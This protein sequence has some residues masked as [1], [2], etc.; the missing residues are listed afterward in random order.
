MHA[1]LLVFHRW[2]ALVVSVLIL[3]IALTGSALVFEGA[4][5]RGLH[6]A[7]WRVTPHEAPMSL[8][9]LLSRARTVSPKVPI[10]GITLPACW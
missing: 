4:L 8:D 5:D 7:L 6:P 2:L 10:T 9:T 3:V 1:V